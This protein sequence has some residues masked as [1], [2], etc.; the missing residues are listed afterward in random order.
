MIYLSLGLDGVQCFQHSNYSLWPIA[1]KI[2]NLHP[3]ERTSGE[4]ILVTALIPGPDKP[5]SF[6][7]YLQSVFNEVNSS[8]YGIKILDANNEEK[9]IFF[10]H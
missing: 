2:W 5:K 4:F 1:V 8:K 3:A 9:T 7:P 10:I 6:T